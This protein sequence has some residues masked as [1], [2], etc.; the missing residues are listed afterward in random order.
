MPFSLK[1]SKNI[2]VTSRHLK[3]SFIL[4]LTNLLQTENETKSVKTIYTYTFFLYKQSKI[5]TITPKISNLLKKI[6]KL[7]NPL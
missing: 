3:F 2:K 5:Y 7:S 6:R 4:I 1:M